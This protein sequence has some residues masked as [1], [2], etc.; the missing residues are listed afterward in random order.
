MSLYT[1][2]LQHGITDYKHVGMLVPV[3][4]QPIPE[5]GPSRFFLIQVKLQVSIS[6]FK[7]SHKSMDNCIAKSQELDLIFK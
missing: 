3:Q 2:G 6:N 7:S 5:L 4:T 1:G